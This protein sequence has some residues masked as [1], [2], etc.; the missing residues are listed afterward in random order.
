MPL[1]FHC[2]STQCWMSYNAALRA[3]HMGYTQVYWYRGG[4][5]AWQS[6]Q[7][8]ASAGMPAHS[9]QQNHGYQM[10]TDQR[11]PFHY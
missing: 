4:V 1:V 3:I 6:V 9:G 5:E 11:M 10:A 2:Q 7:Q 8:A